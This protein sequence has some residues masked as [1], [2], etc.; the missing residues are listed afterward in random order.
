MSI[1]QRNG[2][3]QGE[4]PRVGISLVPIE[5]MTHFGAI[6]FF[7]DEKKFGFL[8]PDGGGQDVFVHQ[9]TATLYGFRRG[10]LLK[11]MRVGFCIGPQQPGKR[12]EATALAIA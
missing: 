9:S 11:G 5:H 1:Q 6:K 4:R 2:F 8:I 10:Q 3:H 7:D 12:P